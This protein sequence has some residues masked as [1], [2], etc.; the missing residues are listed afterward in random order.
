MTFQELNDKLAKVQKALEAI[1]TGSYKDMD[2][3]FFSARKQE[4][5][6]I[7]EDLEN[8]LK[9]IKEADQGTVATDDEAQAEKLAK[10]GINVRLTNEAEGVQFTQEETRQIAKKVGAAVAKAVKQAGDELKSIKAARIEP[11]SF[12]ID[13]VFKNGNEDQFS[14]YIDEDTLH[15]DDFSYDR[16]LVDVGVKPSGE[17][18]VNVDVLANELVKNFRYL[19]EGEHAADKYNVNV[20]GYQTKHYK[21][22]PGAKSF[23]EKVVAGDHGKVNEEEAK[24]LAKLHDLLFLYEIKALKD[25]DYAA[26]ILSQAEYVVDTIKDQANSM[27]LPADEINY[28]DSHIEKIKDAAEDTNEYNSGLYYKPSDSDMKPVI[29]KDGKPLEEETDENAFI[30]MMGANSV[31]DKNKPK[32]KDEKDYSNEGAEKHYIKV[33]KAEYQ[34]TMQVIDNN[35]YGDDVADIVDDDGNGN[36]IIYFKHDENLYDLVM[37]LGGYDIDVVDHTSD[38]QHYDDVDEARDINDPALMKFRAA[39]IAAKKKAAQRADD[40][41]AKAIGDNPYNSRK[42]SLVAKLK[43]MR[44]QIVR[45]MEQE[46]EP[47]GG[48]IADAYA[49]KLMKI[50]A[51]LAKATGKKE[52][53]Y[54]LTKEDLDVGHQDD[55]PSMLKNTAYESATYAAKLYKKLAQYDQH[56]GEVDFPNWWQ[57]KLI[58][59]K[60]YLSKAFHYLDSEEKQ[61]MLDKL[62]LQEG[63]WALGSAED[64]RNVIKALDQMIDLKDPKDIIRYISKLDGYLYNVVGDDLFHDDLDGAQREAKEGNLDRAHN[65]LIDAQGRAE[66]LLKHVESYTFK[67]SKLKEGSVVYM[68]HS[69]GKIQK[70]HGEVVAKMKELAKQYKAGDKSVVS[71]LKDLTA[72]K[73]ELEKA[74]E[75]KVS[76][77]GNNQQLGH[78]DQRLDELSGDQKEALYDLENILDQAAQLGEEAREIFRQHFPS[79]LGKGDAYGAFELGS[80]ANKYDTTLGS[81]IDEIQ[82]HGDEMEEGK[83]KSDAQRKAVHAAKAEKNEGDESLNEGA[84][85]CGR[86]GRVHV[87]GSGCKRPYLKGKDHCRNN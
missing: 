18:I 71:Q 13:V 72:K 68:N 76:S 64:I 3:S 41:M 5:E 38:A 60:D 35:A 15:L 47:E 46:A 44:A 4:L 16:E 54:S 50:D 87:K 61:P 73:R 37:D 24:R 51:A 67:E 48:P 58:L 8:Q 81:L 19:Q 80:S 84:T 1:E 43:A 85:C 83:Y 6:T 75:K 21:I 77:I 45:D 65:R 26:K 79:M 2:A 11:N 57:S 36:V 20:F 27:G 30:A 31:K 33:P 66:E 70:T 23:M 25:S 22:C 17:A 62:A 59:A 82:E 53:T 78:D 10:K 74:L 29:D 42:D 49:E 63:V 34:P 69:A 9:V 32:E 52:P 7:K 12:D 39:K 86:C 55:E 14:F 28:L 40:R 56:D